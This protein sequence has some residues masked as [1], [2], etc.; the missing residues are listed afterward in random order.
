MPTETCQMLSTVWWL[1]EPELAQN[2]HKKN[3]IH[4]KLKN[5]KHGTCKWVCETEANYRMMI[6]FGLKMCEEYRFRYGRRH[7]VHDKIEFFN[8]TRSPTGFKIEGQ[9]PFY[10]AMPDEYKDSDPVVAYRKL[11]MSDEKNYLASWKSR[12][13]PK[14]WVW[15]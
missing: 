9:T 4:E 11:Y 14:W 8:R 15:P 2:W 3:M 5:H 1:L 12:G 13:P 10:L 6:T 7:G